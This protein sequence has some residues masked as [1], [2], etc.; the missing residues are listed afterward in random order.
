MWTQFN[1]YARKQKNEALSNCFE[2]FSIL[3]YID[4]KTVPVCVCVCVYAS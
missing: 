4:L 2:I 3:E 1:T